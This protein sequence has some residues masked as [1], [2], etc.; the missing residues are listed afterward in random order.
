MPTFY[1]VR[2]GDKERVMGNPALTEIGHAQAKKTAQ[3]L[4]Q[5]PISKVV[6][7]PY[8]RTQ[9]TAKHIAEELD[10]EVMSNDFL[11][12]RA[13]WGE[14]PEQTI[15]HFFEEWNKATWER[16]F[17]PRVGDTSIAAGKRLEKAVESLSEAAEKESEEHIVLVTHGGIIADFLRNVFEDEKLQHLI[18]EFPM[19]KGYEVPE[20]SV[21]IIERKEDG[22]NLKELVAV[23]HLAD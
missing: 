4:K 6:A 3:F 17:Q 8:L 7:S 14:D 22:L 2:H 12:E 11:K 16:E 5:F 19:G 23:A 9:Q 13:N 21:T 1:L 15:Q 10:L 20:C 18:I